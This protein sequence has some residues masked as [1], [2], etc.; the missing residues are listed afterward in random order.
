MKGNAFGGFNKK[1]DKKGGS[2]KTSTNDGIFGFL[3]NPFAKKEKI[4]EDA[5]VNQIDTTGMTQRIMTSLRPENQA[6]GAGGQST[7][8][9]FLRTEENWKRLK[10]L[11]PSNVPQSMRR[12]F[13]IEDGGSGDP[14]AWT[15]LNQQQGK[16]LDFDVAICGG[17]LGK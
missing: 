12:E 7:Y 17:T 5:S 2:K 15:K 16:E 10:E 3:K 6:G 4:V 1:D 11:D 9:A 14:R 8:D 13:V